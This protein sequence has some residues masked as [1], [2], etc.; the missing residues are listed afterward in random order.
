MASLAPRPAPSSGARVRNFLGWAFA[1]SLVLH[2]LGGPLIPWK[3]AHSEE[4]QVE[5]VSDTKKIKVKPPTPPP[6][7]PTP[8]PP[9]PPP[10]STP[11]PVHS[12]QPPPQPKLRVEPPKTNSNSAGTNSK[13][14]R[15]N[16]TSGSQNGVPAGV[17][18]AAPAAPAAAP[19][20]VPV[21]TPPPAPPPTPK[22]SC[23]NPNAAASMSNK[24]TPETPE[25]AKEQGVSGTAQV[26]VSLGASGGVLGV[27]IYKSAGSPALDQAALGAARQSSYIPAKENCTNVSGDYLYTVEFT[28]Q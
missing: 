1:I 19:A 25:I 3:Q 5:K 14:S 6:P 26:K 20:K 2:L 15:Y 24:V 22:V 16:V 13:E 23:A 4:Q 17:A 27:S 12:T 7:S 10:K 11:P 8:P 28:S 18:S 21:S 9:T